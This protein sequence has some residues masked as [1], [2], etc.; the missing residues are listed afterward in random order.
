MGDRKN[1]MNVGTDKHPIWLN[2]QAAVAL[3]YMAEGISY[4]VRRSDHINA[5]LLRDLLVFEGGDSDNR[6]RVKATY[7]AALARKRMRKSIF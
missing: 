5:L 3:F 4:I 1:K 6:I 7:K 2:A